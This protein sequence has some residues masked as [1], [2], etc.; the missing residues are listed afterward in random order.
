MKSDDVVG[1]NLAGIQLALFELIWPSFD[2]IDTIYVASSPNK[3]SVHVQAAHLPSPGEWDDCERLLGEVFGAVLAEA[4]L[5]LNLTH[6][7]NPPARLGY[8]EVMS[9]DIFKMIAKDVA[10]WRL[11]AGR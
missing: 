6:D 2:W 4:N 10:P 1:A 8:Q 5:H 11:D 3:C 9:H 7:K